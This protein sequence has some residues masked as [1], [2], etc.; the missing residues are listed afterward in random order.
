MKA[1]FVE[2]SLGLDQKNKNCYSV[3][4][5]K[6]FSPNLGT[7]RKTLV[8]RRP[9]LECTYL[10]FPGQTK[11]TAEEILNFPIKHTSTEYTFEI[12]DLDG[13][14]EL[15]KYTH[16]KRCNEAKI[17]C[18]LFL[19]A[20]LVAH[21]SKNDVFKFLED[22]KKGSEVHI[23]TNTASEANDNRSEDIKMFNES[24]DL[25]EERSANSENF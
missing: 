16:T 22:I 23:R 13:K 19:D 21:T 15:W 3:S 9:D 1:Q 4:E 11:Y 5:I 7:Y 17:K 24:L 8:T 6:N 20:K 12:G 2:S 25:F 18:F 14:K 10:R